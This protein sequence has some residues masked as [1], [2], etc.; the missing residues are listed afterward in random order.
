MVRQSQL[1]GALITV[2]ITVGMMFVFTI[3]FGPAMDQ[4]ELV[5]TDMLPGMALPAQWN[6]LAEGV[7]NN[8]PMMWKAITA[9][10]IA[11]GV[12]V[13]RITFFSNEYSGEF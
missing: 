8:W 5:F 13:V 12:W 9:I 4:L 1:T 10:V 11:V 7:L 2:L 6:T 3:T